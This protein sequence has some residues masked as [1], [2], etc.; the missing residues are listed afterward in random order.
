[1]LNEIIQTHQGKRQLW[2]P[3]KKKGRPTR[4]DSCLECTSRLSSDPSQRRRTIREAELLHSNAKMVGHVLLSLL[5]RS[6]DAIVLPDLKHA[7]TSTVGFPQMPVVGS[8]PTEIIC[9]L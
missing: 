4:P 8:S 5:A 2:M 7:S 9:W 3:C 6:Q 1:M